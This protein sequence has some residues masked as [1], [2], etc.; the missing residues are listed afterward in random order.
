MLVNICQ[1]LLDTQIK[2]MIDVLLQ[3]NNFFFFFFG[4]MANNSKLWDAEIIDLAFSMVY[5]LMSYE[6]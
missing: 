2:Y 6:W 3:T 4:L 5:T 1:K